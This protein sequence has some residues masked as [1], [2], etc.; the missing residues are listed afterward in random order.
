MPHCVL[1]YSPNLHPLPHLAEFFEALHHELSKDSVVELG[2][3]KSRTRMCENCY[4]GDGNQDRAFLYLQISLLSGREEAWLSQVS[5]AALSLLR[6]SFSHR[7][8]S[9][10]PSVT[11]EIREMDKRF[12][13]A[14]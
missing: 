3:I 2:R 9:H 4:V 14:H 11:V 13:R 8:A 12:H 1:E 7:I 6:R 5:D 10:H